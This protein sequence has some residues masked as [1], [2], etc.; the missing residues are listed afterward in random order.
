MKKFLKQKDNLIIIIISLIAFIVGCLSIGMLK[1]FLIIGLADI[2]FFIPNMKKSKKP[3]KRTSSKT[4]K[5]KKKKFI[6]VLLIFFIICVTMGIIGTFAFA[7]YI[8][9]TAPKFDSNKLYAQESSVLYDINGEVFAKLGTEKREKISYEELPEVLI[10]AIVATEDSK[11]FQHNGFDLARFL[12]ASA[13]QVLSAGSSGGGAST[14]TM[15]VVKNNLTNDK[16]KMASSGVNGILRKFTDIYVSIFK[17]EKKYSKKEILEFYVNAYYLGSGAYGVEQ[18]SQTYFGKSAKD[19]NLSEAAIIAG[20]FQ[21][22]DAYDPY[23]HPELAEQRRSTVLYLME[24]HGYISKEEREI[25]NS[26]PVE[27]LLNKNAESNS[28]KWQAFI[29]TVVVEIMEKTKSKEN[30]NGLNAYSVPMEIYTTM[31]PAKQEN[32]NKIMSGESYKWPNDQADAGIAVVDVNNGSIVAIGK[33]RNMSTKLGLNNA[34]QNIKQIGSTS[35][36]ILDYGTG[37]E[38]NNWSTYTLYADEPYAYSNG[39]GVSNWD[40]GFNGL[41]TLRT[42]VGQSRNIPAIKAFQNNENENIVKF[43]SSLGLHLELDAN[44]KAHE[45]HAIGGYGG[46]TPLTMAAAYAAFGNGG[47]YIKPYSF[48][49]VIFKDTNKV[50]ETKANKTKVMSDATAYMMADLLKSTAVMSMYNNYN[51]GATYGAK[52][53]TSNFDAATI[54]AN[55]YGPDAVNDLWVTGTSPDYAISVWYGYVKRSKDYVSTSYTSNHRSL[56]QAAARGIF[57]PGSDWK[58]PD[59]V[60]EV[61][62]EFGTW[63][64]KLASEHTPS[65]LRVTEL[66]KEGTEPTEVSDRFSKLDSVT[67]LKGTINGNKLK[68]SWT[69]INPNAINDNKITDLFTSLY[70]NEGY[71]NDAINSRKQYNANNIGTIIYKVYSKDNAGNLTLLKETSETSLTIDISSSSPSK[72]VVVASYSIFK[73]NASDGAEVTV[74]LKNV[75]TNLSATLKS[76]STEISVGST[77]TKPTDYSTIMTVMDGSIDVTKKATITETYTKDGSTV[78]TIN[79]TAADTYKIKYTITYNGTSITKTR[80]LKVTE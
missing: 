77:Y 40:R 37:I 45:A 42:A 13:T 8:V 21:A 52:T 20:L 39:T 56:F 7:L 12:K 26:I 76:E 61:E 16:Y 50:M 38:Y 19:L 22:P 73:A 34:T 68:L 63:P 49:K 36:P 2:I 23:Q 70:S 27:N 25:A 30:P 11:F 53:G 10:D 44:G 65:D 31:D 66:F 67:N 75:S 3:K 74:S 54:A 5:K 32:I 14:L 62:I 17:V 15:Q 47:Y 64:A 4:E 28:N 29:D 6:R 1:A 46:E 33:G 60:L 9:K 24:R 18:A 71:R 72:Y 35:K 69:G 41:M 59:D 43:A 57:K 48:T 78:S 55:G 80:T 79:T 58:K 51:V